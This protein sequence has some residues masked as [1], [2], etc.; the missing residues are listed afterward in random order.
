MAT[1]NLV[2]ELEARTAK[3]EAGLA[4]VDRDLN[5]VDRSA[6]KTSLSLKQM[7][8][9]A[10]GVAASISAATI[11]GIAFVDVAA[12]MGRELEVAARRSGV[13]VEEMQKLA[14][15]SNTVGISVEKLGD[16]FKDTQERIGDFLATGGGPFQDFVD[17]MNLSTSQAR[18]LAEQFEKMSG[19]DVLKSMVA[20]M[21]AAGVSGQ[22]MS[23]ALEGMA[24]DS[25]DLIPLLTD[26]AKGMDELAESTEAA[27]TVLSQ[28]E[29]DQ[30]Q[31][32]AKKFEDIKKQIGTDAARA[33]AQ[34]SEQIFYLLD[35]F[36][37]VGEAGQAWADLNVTWWKTVAEAAKSALDVITGNLNFEEFTQRMSESIDVLKEKIMDFRDAFNTEEDDNK[38]PFDAGSVTGGDKEVEAAE[39]K[40]KKIASWDQFIADRKKLSDEER[41]K[42]EQGYIRAASILG[43]AFLEDNKALQAGL[44]I[45]DTATGIMRAFATSGNIYEA[46][47]NAAIVAAT[48]I[49][50]LANLQSASKGGGSISS[51]SGGGATPA[52][53]PVTDTEGVEVDFESVD[54]TGATT[55]IRFEASDGDTIGEALAEWLNERARNT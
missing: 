31:E 20:Q 24:S 30:I 33:V 12:R 26:G 32:V 45:A 37:R 55:T 35:V 17:V 28:K 49:T 7:S 39:E 2:V 44:I 1:E 15:A 53:T 48:G 14:Y 27:A 34:Y 5:K 41:L 38:G 23:F 47:A 13:T 4:T 46:Y 42:S 52:A 50:Q 21:E 43:N 16:I 51:G 3:L 36:K 10:A 18:E 9:A 11:A 40:A 22:K 6:K 19:P 8:T 29:I 54:A 25:T